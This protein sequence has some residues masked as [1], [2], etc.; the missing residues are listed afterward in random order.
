MT[1]AEL[2]KSLDVKFPKKF[3]EI[4]DT[5]AM[6]WIEVGN[7][8]FN[9]NREHYLNDPKAFMMLSC[10]CEPIFFEDISDCINS[11]YII[12]L[13]ELIKWREEYMNEKLDEKFRL[14]P[15]AMNGG[16]DFYCF[17][18]EKGTD[19]PK[20]VMVAHDTC[21]LPDVIGKDFD[22]FLYIM[23]MS[24]VAYAVDDDDFSE[25]EGEQWENNLNYLNDEYRSIIQS[26]DRYKLADMYW[27]LDFDMAE[28]FS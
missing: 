10:D 17:L 6:E 21:D 2:E 8:K 20:I 27:S 14:I 7:E 23:M 1:L 22:E 13:N 28:I 5:G 26:A 25:L 15:F 18:Y 12:S 16:G 3:H 9:E 4:Y 24:C 19:E 11:D